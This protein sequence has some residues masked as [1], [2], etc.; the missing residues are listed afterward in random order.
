[1]TLTGGGRDEHAAGTGEAGDFAEDARV[2]GFELDIAQSGLQSALQQ[3]ADGVVAVRRGD[4]GAK[5]DGV[6]GVKSQ[7]IIESLG[8]T[9]ES[10]VGNELLDGSF[11]RGCV[12][13]RRSGQ[14]SGERALR[15]AERMLA[16]RYGLGKVVMVVMM[17]VV[18][19]GRLNLG[20]FAK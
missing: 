19:A 18:L 13:E 5:D 11:G 3:L 12:G 17:D 2:G 7:E 14:F 10:P 6:G 4:V 16:E 9:A 15:I 8:V 1:M 20:A